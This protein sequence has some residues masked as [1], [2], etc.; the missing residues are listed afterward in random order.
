MEPSALT[1]DKL[2]AL[3]HERSSMIKEG[4]RLPRRT[5]DCFSKLSNELIVRITDF[6]TGHDVLRLSQASSI[7]F[8]ATDDHGFWRSLVSREM[9]WLWDTLPELLASDDDLDWKSIYTIFDNATGQPWGMQ[10]E[11]MSL[12][13][14]RRIWSACNQLA[15]HYQRRLGSFRNVEDD[16]RNNAVSLQMPAVSHPEP[17]KSS[18]FCETIPSWDARASGAVLSVAWNAKSELAGI[19]FCGLQDDRYA[20]IDAMSISRGDWLQSLTLFLQP[21]DIWSLTP[22]TTVGAVVGAKV[23]MS[24]G[25][26]H[27]IGDTSPGHVRRHLAP[28][29][30]REIVGF[31]GR[32][33]DVCTPAR[34]CVDS[35]A[36]SRPRNSIEFM[37]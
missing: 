20:H 33:D 17:K 37:L 22:T 24:S 26:A 13:N 36:N 21:I 25:I 7:V 29:Q 18:P 14:R 15:V 19:S 3:L 16:F 9:G 31:Q 2:R 32:V 27:N 6:L 23:L 8:Q 34:S 10:G 12:A 35:T 1:S 5:T 30:G 11:Y 4:T 28:S